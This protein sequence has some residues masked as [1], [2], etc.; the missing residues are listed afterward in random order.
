MNIKPW[1]IYLWRNGDKYEGA[2]PIVTKDGVKEIFCVGWEIE[3]EPLNK[4]NEDKH[5][6]WRAKVKVKNLLNNTLN[7]I[8]WYGKKVLDSKGNID[9]EKLKGLEAT[10][11]LQAVQ[12]KVDMDDLYKIRKFPTKDITIKEANEYGFKKDLIQ[13]R[14]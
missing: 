11:A 9:T 4:R 12:Q 14:L 3:S 8:N 5:Q 2:S 1:T 6:A 13:K 7:V 10:T